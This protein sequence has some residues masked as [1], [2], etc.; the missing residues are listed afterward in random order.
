[1]LGARG[2]RDW[3]T[4]I[5]VSATRLV[6]VVLFLTCVR[7]SWIHVF[8]YIASCRWWR[9]VVIVWWV[10]CWIVGWIW[11]VRKVAVHVSRGRCWRRREVVGF[12]EVAGFMRACGRL[13]WAVLARAVASA[14]AVAALAIGRLIFI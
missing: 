1:V 8:V 7:I 2:L 12:W 4:H 10:V 3:S 11:G 5:L 6:V 13:T 9:T 14:R